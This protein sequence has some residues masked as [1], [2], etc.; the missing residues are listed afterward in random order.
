MN[1]RRLLSITLFFAST[2]G[3]SG[4]A[5]DVGALKPWIEAQGELKS[6][7]GTFT[8]ERK[9]K[10]LRKTLVAPGRFW[11]RAPNQFRWDIGDPVRS[12]AIQSADKFTVIDL[13][14]GKAEVKAG[15]SET[16]R[17]TAYLQM[18]FPRDWEAFQREFRVL[19][20]ERSGNVLRVGLEPL[21]PGA[22][23][24]V[25]AIRFEIDAKSYATQAFVLDL[26][27]GSEMRTSFS[28]VERDAGVPRSVFD[29]SL[30]GLRVKD[31]G[32]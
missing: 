20:V 4:F 8:Q 25:R 9:L 5:A 7:T 18:S 10:V 22:A 13:E 14:K 27:D 17:L 11:Y 28:G 19:S 2:L 6:L 3:P 32:L 26:K 16:N 12:V 24:G 23:R 15:E 31:K 21:D 30:E 1:C 29:V